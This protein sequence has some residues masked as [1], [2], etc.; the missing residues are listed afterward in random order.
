M[1]S[2]P[3]VR[4][5]IGPA[6]VRKLD[7]GCSDDLSASTTSEERIEMVA[8]LSR[9]MWELTGRPIPTYARHEMPVR[10]VRRA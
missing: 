8:V 4:P 2:E 10:V 3:P 9:R 1:N 5:G 7:E 6:I